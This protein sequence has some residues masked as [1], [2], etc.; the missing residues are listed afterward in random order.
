MKILQ[1]DFFPVSNIYDNVVNALITTG[2]GQSAMIKSMDDLRKKFNIFLYPTLFKQ[3]DQDISSY[4]NKIVPLFV[5]KP[6]HIVQPGLLELFHVNYYETVKC[7]ICGKWYGQN[8]V[9]LAKRTLD[10]TEF[11]E[12]LDEAAN[13]N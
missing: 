4:L 6:D 12:D 11:M 2:K 7:N 10:H 9:A 5:S 13:F 1:K 8:E 3:S